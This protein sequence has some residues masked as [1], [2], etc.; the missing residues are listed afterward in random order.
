[1]KTMSIQFGVPRA[2]ASLLLLLG[3]LF[4]PALAL[5]LGDR[6]TLPDSVAGRA[7]FERRM[8][9]PHRPLPRPHTSGAVHFDLLAKLL[10]DDRRSTPLCACLAQL[11]QEQPSFRVATQSHPLLG[12]PAPDFTLLDHQGR[13]WRLGELTAAGPVVLVFYL[14]YGCDACVHNLFEIDADLAKFR[15]LGAEAVAISSDSAA[16]TCDRFARYGTFGFP[17]LSDADNLVAKAYG[18]EAPTADGEAPP[19]MHATFVVGRD[20][21]VIWANYGT[22]PFRGNLA[23]LFEL[24]RANRQTSPIDP[25]LASDPPKESRDP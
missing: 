20:G 7:A 17:V 9:E 14:G 21:L 23:L 22:A 6:P 15:A 13:A 24:R 4:A 10:A 3:A 11:D 2:A 8:S 12:Q 1:M 18:V 5:R 16:V 25:A 19:R